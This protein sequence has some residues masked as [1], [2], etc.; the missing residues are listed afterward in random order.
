MTVLLFWVMSPLIYR[1][2]VESRH[3]K[4]RS[5][6]LKTPVPRQLWF[7]K[8]SNQFRQRDSSIK[9]AGTALETAPPL[10]KA[11]FFV[12]LQLITS[13]TTQGQTAKEE[14]YTKESSFSQNDWIKGTA[15]PSKWNIK[16]YIIVFNNVFQKVSLPFFW[17]MD[18]HPEYHSIISYR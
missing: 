13:V 4:N 2:I 17:Q 7:W 11:I 6:M 18:N 8:L 16:W 3:W 1:W 9:T 12:K 14:R 5:C 15:L 10:L